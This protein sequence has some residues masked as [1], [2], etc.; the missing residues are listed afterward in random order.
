MSDVSLG[1]DSVGV[2]LTLDDLGPAALPETDP[3]ANGT[4]R[5]TDY[6]NKVDDFRNPDVH[7]MDLRLEKDFL[8]SDWT[9]T[10]LGE[11]FNVLNS[12]D[13]LQ[14]SHRLRFGGSVIET[15]DGGTLR[16]AGGDYVTEVVSPRVFRLGA[17]VSFR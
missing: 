3:L 7:L 4:F 15:G 17:R 6:T 12:S 8:F 16:V 1:Q 14:T 10:L 11:V 2:D 5:P 9:F 13:P